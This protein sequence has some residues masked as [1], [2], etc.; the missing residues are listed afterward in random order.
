MNRLGLT[1]VVAALSL[2]SC[3]DQTTTNST[4]DDVTTLASTTVKSKGGSGIVPI[5]WSPTTYNRISDYWSGDGEATPAKVMLWFRTGALPDAN[6]NPTASYYWLVAGAADGTNKVFR[7]YTVANR[8]VP[9]YQSMQRLN[10]NLHEQEPEVLTG[11]WD[12][13]AGNG[14]GGTPVHP[15]GGPA[16]FPVED[17]DA[18]LAAAA[19]F[20]NSYFNFEQTSAAY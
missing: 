14:G 8:L 9:T 16:G 10:L 11:I 20:R 5:T 15:I 2:A 6:G 1:V 4:Q 19:A 7:V 18:V 3:V 13:G 12:G 17:M